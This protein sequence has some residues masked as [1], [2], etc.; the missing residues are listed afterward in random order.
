MASAGRAIYSSVTIVIIVV[1]TLT[2]VATAGHSLLPALFE[3]TKI[4]TLGHDVNGIIA[5]TSVLALSLLWIRGRSVLDLWLMVAVC[6]L[7]EE[8][9]LTAFFLTARFTLGFYAIRLILLFVSKVVLLTLVSQTLSLQTSLSTAIRNLRREHANRLTTA[10]AVVAAIAHEVRQP[11]AAIRLNAGAGQRF[12][13]RAE[14]GPKW[15]SFSR[16]H[17]RCHR[18]SE[19]SV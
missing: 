13:K 10:E 7:A 14:P 8:G 2:W 17:K 3:N 12:L 11:L 16:G 15:I 6:A 18:S 19:R 1:C 4:S 9:L 5:L